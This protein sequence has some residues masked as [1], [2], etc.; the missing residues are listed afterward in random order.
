MSNAKREIY[1]RLGVQ[2]RNNRRC[3]KAEK[4][5]PGAMGLYA[6]LVIDARAELPEV[7]GFVSEEVALSAWGGDVTTRR[8]QIDALCAVDLVER[9]AGGVVVVK[10]DEHNDTRKTVEKNKKNTR[11][12]VAK[13]RKDVT[14]YMPVTEGVSNAFVPNS[15]ST[16]LSL[17]GSPPDR[18]PVAGCSTGQPPDWFA[19]AVEVIAMGTGVRL[20][21]AEAWLRY[22]GHRANKSIAPTQR[23]AQYWLTTVMVPEAREVA[24][25]DARDGERTKAF[26]AQRSGPEVKPLP[27]DAPVRRAQAEWERTAAAP[28]EQAEAARRLQRMLGGIGR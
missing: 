2:L 24:R 13:H 12:R 11:L 25:R 14:R 17:S 3:F 20:P 27:S 19:T 6:F 18:D 26:V 1:A 10:Y 22:D 21:V 15:I 4:L 8:L 7:D 5:A 16:S 23:D 28:E 9:V